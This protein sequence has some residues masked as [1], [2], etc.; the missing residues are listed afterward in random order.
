MRGRIYK[1]FKLKD[2]SRFVQSGSPEEW[3]VYGIVK[4][5]FK[6]IFFILLFPIIIPI[7]LILNF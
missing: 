3:F 4:F 5:I 1:I 6:V 7:K 2:G